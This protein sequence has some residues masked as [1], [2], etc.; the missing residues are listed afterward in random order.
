[1]MLPVSG[2]R[3]L[4]MLADDPSAARFLRAKRGLIP[5]VCD[6]VVVAS[7]DV[8]EHTVTLQVLDEA[9]DV[10]HTFP[11]PRGTHPSEVLPTAIACIHAPFN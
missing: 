11:V 2:E 7:M 5:K 6:D 1:M 3:A 8:V 9:N 4:R 10:V